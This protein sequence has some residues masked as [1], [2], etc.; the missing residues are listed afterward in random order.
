MGYK[1]VVDTDF[2]LDDKVVD[3]FSPEDRLFFLYLMTNPHTTQLGVYKLIRKVMAFEIGYSVEAVNTLLERFEKQYGM[4]RY[5][6]ATS[7][8]AVRNY[9]RYSIVKGGKP[10]EDLLLKEIRQVRDKSLLDF[11]FQS[12]STDPNLNDSVKSAILKYMNGND[13]DNDNENEN[14]VSSHESYHES[15]HESSNPQWKKNRNKNES[16]NKE[17]KLRDD[18]RKLAESLSQQWQSNIDAEEANKEIRTT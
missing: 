2:W 1:R 7:E 6:E 17:Q 13:N 16:K 9:L 11:V 8:I 5:S 18:F 4:I 10:V 12:I 3:C 14:D 15:Y